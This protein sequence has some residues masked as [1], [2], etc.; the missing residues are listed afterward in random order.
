MQIL[1]EFIIDKNIFSKKD[2]KEY[3]INKYGEI[4][5]NILKKIKKILYQIIKEDIK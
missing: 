4:K 1:K 3:F 5:Y 2:I